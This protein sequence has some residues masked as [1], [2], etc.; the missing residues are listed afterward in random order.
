MGRHRIYNTDEER[1]EAAKACKRKYYNKH[2][3][4]RRDNYRLSAL[5]C[6]YVKKLNNTTDENIR[7][8]IIAKINSIQEEINNLP[9]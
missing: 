7:N 5:K 4:S 1:H 2:K 3:E 8:K 9:K 6:Y